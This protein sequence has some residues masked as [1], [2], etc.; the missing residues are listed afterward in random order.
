ML[1]V[2]VCSCSGIYAALSMGQVILA[3]ISTIVPAWMGVRAAVELHNRSFAA[4]LRAPMAFFDTT[5]VGRI[6]NRFSRDQ[7]TIDSLL[8]DTLRMILS[9]TRTAFL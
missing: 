5:P 7:D 1:H 3:L 6:I 8:M 9:E 2:C 4:V